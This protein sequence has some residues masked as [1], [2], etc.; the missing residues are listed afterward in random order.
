MLSEPDNID[1][2]W[3]Q[4]LEPNDYVLCSHMTAEPRALLA[5]LAKTTLP[6]GLAVDLGVPFSL[7]AQALPH[8]VPLHVMGGMGSASRI[9]KDRPL[10]INRDDYLNVTQQYAT[11]NR[12]ADIVLLSL[13]ADSDG[14]LHL[15]ASH[16]AALDAAYRA[17]HVIAEINSA[18]PVI[19]GAPWPTDI[20]VSRYIRCNYSIASVEPSHSIK[21]Q[22]LQI[23]EHLAELIPHAACLQVGIGSLP[24]AILSSL[25]SHRHLGIHTGMLTDSSYELI[26]RG[27]VDNSCKPI[28]FQHSVV[29]SVYGS[30]QLYAA[31][32]ENSQVVL[33]PT[34]YTHALE[35]L[36]QIKR[37]TAINSTLEVDLLGRVN[38]E[39][40]L[41]PTGER[42]YVGGV[43]GLPNVVR[44]ALAA[45]HGMSIIALPALTRYDD[46]ARSRIVA[47][48]SS[49][50]TL[51]ETLADFV[52]TEHGVASL[53]GA[54][55]SQRRERMI[56]IA[57]PTARDW[58]GKPVRE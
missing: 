18:A 13:A 41:T 29:G 49:E 24:A 26:N 48:L 46:K 38:S 50:V 3:D 19:A 32:A 30:A 58:L 2:P 56:A 31:A 14:T 35:V 47:S 27:A 23:A 39:S 43:G 12:R 34:A 28:E 1:L 5:S 42:R 55:A 4:W 52:V 53:R 57:D 40:V 9:A 6:A 44:G 11:G 16:G 33:K 45:T 17:R 36:Q 21:P 22:E 25:D 54:N 37:F 10:I 20:E 15:G 51:D 7:D 8:S